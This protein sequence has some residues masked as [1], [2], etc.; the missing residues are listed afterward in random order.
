[1]SSNRYW[2]QVNILFF[3]FVAS[4]VKD[5]LEGEQWDRYLHKINCF[6]MLYL[7]AA[8]IFMPLNMATLRDSLEEKSSLATHYE[9]TALW[10][11]K[12]IPPS[13]TIYHLYWDE[14][15]YF[16]CL[17]PKDNYISV[18]D[19]IYMYYSYPDVFK[20]NQELQKGSMPNPHEIIRVVFGA[21]Y[22]YIHKKY[23]K[24]LYDQ[25]Q[26]D[27]RHFKI[28]FNDNQ[29]IVFEILNG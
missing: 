13:E 3:V 7:T 6:I 12:N 25:I 9:N 11:K 4:Y 10:M 20:I 17:N 19:P 2:Y 5:L 24:P 21:K 28:I 23:A 29:G 8:I 16:I 26:K 1:M 27:P 14:S 18:L 15:P 22:G